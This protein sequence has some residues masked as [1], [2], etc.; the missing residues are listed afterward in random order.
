M[1]HHILLSIDDDRTSDVLDAFSEKLKDLGLEMLQTQQN[2]ITLVSV[3]T[4]GANAP[5]EEPAPAE[6]LPPEPEAVEPEA[7]VE[8][9]AEPEADA[10]EVEIEMKFESTCRVLDLSTTKQFLAAT[11]TDEVSKLIVSNVDASTK[12]FVSFTDGDTQYKFPTNEAGLIEASVDT[13]NKIKRIKLQVVEAD[14]DKNLPVGAVLL[15]AS[16][17]VLL[18]AGE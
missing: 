4:A 9:A 16:D 10:E 7:A 5:V 15:G 12:G 8:P 2:G 17:A 11:G 18:T 3:A 14:A 13:A 1:T 6:E